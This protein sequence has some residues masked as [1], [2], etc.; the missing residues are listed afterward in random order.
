MTKEDI[1]KKLN[2]YK[3]KP[4]EIGLADEGALLHSG[5]EGCWLFING[6]ALVEIKKNTG[7]GTYGFL[8]INQQ[9]NPY[10]VTTVNMDTVNYIRSYIGTD[11]EISNE[12]SGLAPI[13]TSKSMEE[14]T[15]EIQGNS[16]RKANSPRGFSGFTNV[17]TGTSYGKFSGSAI[18]TDIDGL[19]KAFDNLVDK[20]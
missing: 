5:I 9:Q 4:I 7:D 19:P 10:V 18:S 6:D 16:I 17:K 8:G 11:Q 20:R 2:D 13:S 3:D 14:I 15:K 12:L 1:I